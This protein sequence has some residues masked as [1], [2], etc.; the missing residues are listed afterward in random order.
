[1]DE[2]LALHKQRQSQAC[3]LGRDEGGAAVRAGHAGMVGLA[4]VAFGALSRYDAYIPV[5]TGHSEHG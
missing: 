4:F 2:V 5:L 1:M 3:A